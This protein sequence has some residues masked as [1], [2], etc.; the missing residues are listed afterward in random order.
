MSMFEFYLWTTQKM[1]RTIF[2]PLFFWL[3]MCDTESVPVFQTCPLFF[4]CRIP[5][6]RL[7]RPDT[8]YL[9]CKFILGRLLNRVYFSHIL[10]TIKIVGKKAMHELPVRC[11]G[12]KNGKKCKYN[13]I[14][15]SV[16]CATV[17]SLSHILSQAV[18]F[19]PFKFLSFIV[20]LLH[21]MNWHDNEYVCRYFCVSLSP[22]HVA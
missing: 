5:G 12:T 21:I 4:A 3:P 15:I 13:A 7:Q 2:A 22:N 6:R 9:A 16:R 18:L 14:L 11:D 19:F 20:E 17:H 1:R 10:C 8:I